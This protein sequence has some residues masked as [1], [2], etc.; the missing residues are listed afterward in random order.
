MAIRIEIFSLSVYDTKA[1]E[2]DPCV[3]HLMMIICEMAM[4]SARPKKHTQN[5]EFIAIG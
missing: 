2:K 5:K 3:S 1:V 4:N